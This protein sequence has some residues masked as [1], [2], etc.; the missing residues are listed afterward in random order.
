[1]F[2][3]FHFFEFIW[4]IEKS[5]ILEMERRNFRELIAQ[6]VWTI[7]QTTIP[8]KAGPGGSYS[9][10]LPAVRETWVQSL[11]WEDSP[12]EGNGYP[13]LYSCLESPHGQRNLA[14]YSS[15][16]LQKVGHDWATFTFHI[17]VKPIQFTEGEIKT[18]KG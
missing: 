11:G 3:W 4:C 15:C 12:G 7:L 16:G 8:V 1:M 18:Q 13:L 17:P 2:L 14:G 10:E 9:K 5:Q 6:L